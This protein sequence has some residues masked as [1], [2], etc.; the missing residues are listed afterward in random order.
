MP[1]THP[2]LFYWVNTIPDVEKS[3]SNGRG[4]NVE[5]VSVTLLDEERSDEAE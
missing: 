4:M 1:P 2:I 3:A 5:V